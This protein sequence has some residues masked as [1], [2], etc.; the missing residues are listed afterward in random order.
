MTSSAISSITDFTAPRTPLPRYTDLRRRGAQ[1][2]THRWM[3]PRAQLRVRTRL[4]QNLN[5]STVGCHGNPGSGVNCV[6]TAMNCSPR[7]RCHDVNGFTR[8]MP[9][10]QIL[11]N[12]N[13]NTSCRRFFIALMKVSI[14]LSRALQSGIRPHSPTLGE[15]GYRPKHKH[16]LSRACTKASPRLPNT[17]PN[18]ECFKSFHS[19][20]EQI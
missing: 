19:L 1:Q 7:P 8:W 5:S 15:C 16:E 14:T 17:T 20:R 12:S 9:R 10:P 2:P 13:T 6:I 18:K 4:E 3:R 11:A